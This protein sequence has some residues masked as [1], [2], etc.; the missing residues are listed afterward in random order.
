MSDNDVFNTD[1]TLTPQTADDLL[2]SIKNEV[3]EPKYKTV[4]DGI[5][6]LGASQEFINKLLAEKKAQEEELA[7]IREEQGKVKS[8]EDVLKQLTAK[9]E[10]K[11]QEQTNHA[12][13]LDQEAVANLVRKELEV[14]SNATLQNNNYNEVQNTLKQKFGD[15]ASEVISRKAEELGTSARELG[16]LAKR[17]PKMVLALFSASKSTVTPTTSSVNLPYNPAPSEL[18]KPDKSL[19]L[20]SSSKDLKAYMLKVK[21]DVYR[22]H[23]IEN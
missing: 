4:A 22:K 15:K 16:E 5:K 11:K 8:I 17:N 21:E 6:A 13:V 19:L 9:D 12:G 23:G 7:R 20:G 2:A 1:N 18:A 14:V 3:G 10:D